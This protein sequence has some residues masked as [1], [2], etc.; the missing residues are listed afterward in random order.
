MNKS[1]IIVLSLVALLAISIYAG[2][3]VA[4]YETQKTTDFELDAN[5]SFTATETAIGVTYEIQGSAGATG[6]ISADV[7]SGNPMPS[8]IVPTG[9]GLTNFII[10]SFNMDPNDFTSGLITFSYTDDDVANLEPPFMIYKYLPDANLYVEMPTTVDEQAK[11]L[12][13]SLTSTD[14][15]LFA[16]GGSEVENTDTE[17]TPWLLIAAVVIIAV[18]ASVLVVLFLRKTNRL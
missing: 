16:I 14:D 12:T 4:Q 13:I 3:A 8:A 15:P 2:S 5:G 11:T 7:Y 18:V 1:K 17:S 6:S 9:I 10:I